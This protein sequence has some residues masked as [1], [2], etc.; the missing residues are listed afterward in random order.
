MEHLFSSCRW[1]NQTFWRR[2]GTENIHLDTGPPNWRKRSKRFSR[3]IRRVSSA[4]SWLISGCRWSDKWFLVHVRKLQKPPSRWTQSQTLLAERR[5]IPCCTEIHWRVQNYTYKLGCYART[6]HP[7]LLE[8]QWVKRFVWSLDRFHTI[9][10]RKWEPPRRTHV[11]WG[12]TD[13]TASDI[14]AR[15][16]MARTLEINGK[17]RQAEGK[18]EVVTWKTPSW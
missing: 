2:S 12:E 7:W 9:Y 5:I 18:A 17:A 3:R 4:T 8:Y 6:P 14:Q 11:V 13:K 15:S 16:S 1:T 10:S